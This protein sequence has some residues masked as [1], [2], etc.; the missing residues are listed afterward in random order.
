MNCKNNI[1][2]TLGPFFS[3][4]TFLTLQYF[5][6]PSAFPVNVTFLVVIW[7]YKIH[8]FE[9]VHFPSWNLC[10]DNGESVLFPVSM[11]TPVKETIFCLESMYSIGY[12]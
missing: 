11:G 5:F 1:F 12:S 6:S 2:L 4:H 3:K 10:F 9:E 7:I 8:V